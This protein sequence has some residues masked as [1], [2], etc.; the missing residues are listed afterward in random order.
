MQIRGVVANVGARILWG[1]AAYYFSLSSA[2][3]ARSLFVFRLFSAFIFALLVCI[4]IRQGGRLARS[5][6]DRRVM[7]ISIFS[8]FL[9][10]SNWFVVVRSVID[11]QLVVSSLGFYIAP[12][13]TVC[14]GIVFL[15]ERFNSLVALSLALCAMAIALLFHHASSFP[16]QVLYIAGTSTAYAYVRK[17]RPLPAVVTNTIETGIAALFAPIIFLTLTKGAW[18]LDPNGDTLIY[19]AGLGV[20]TT[21][22]MLLYVYSLDKIPLALIGYLQYVTPTLMIAI[23]ALIL[24]ETVSPIRVFAIA[25]IWA[26][27]VSWILSQQWLPRGTLNRQEAR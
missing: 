5:L 25:L 27:I 13:L 7:L 23:G 20:V 22:P 26:S 11:G 1:G 3:D 12:I 10:S 21:V 14:C 15:G 18:R 4:C 19:L 16:W 2:T 24:H 6:I 17:L 8:S 9:I